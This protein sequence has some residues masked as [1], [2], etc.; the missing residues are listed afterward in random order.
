MPVQYTNVAGTAE[1]TI[2][3]AA[4]SGGRHSMRRLIITTINAVAATLTLKDSTGGATRA[5]FDYPNAASAPTAPLVVDFSNA[6]DALTQ[7]AQGAPFTLTASVN[8]S[9][10]KVTAVYDED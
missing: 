5:V 9:G 7:S 10:Y 3:P 2:V 8:A 4:P 6:A 1:T